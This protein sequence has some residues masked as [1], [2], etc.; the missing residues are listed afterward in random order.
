VAAATPPV[1]ALLIGSAGYTSAF[2]VAS[3]FPLAAAALV[4]LAA[5]RRMFR[6]A[7]ASP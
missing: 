7:Q 4:P 5:E 1:M 3:L 2:A 6:R